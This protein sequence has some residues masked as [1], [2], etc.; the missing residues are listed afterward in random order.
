[1]PAAQNFL[2]VTLLS[3]FAIS[4]VCHA[5]EKLTGNEIA[6]Q[7]VHQ[8]QR[9]KPFDFLKVPRDNVLI[10]GFNLRLFLRPKQFVQTSFVLVRGPSFPYTVSRQAVI[11]PHVLRKVASP[12]LRSICS[13][14]ITVR[15]NKFLRFKLIREAHRKII[16]ISGFFSIFNVQSKQFKIR[17]QG[18]NVFLVIIPFQARYLEERRPE[19]RKL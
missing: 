15:S 14:R 1:M 12:C 8:A 18:K 4:S 5:A 3:I 6:T 9:P 2:L 7:V 16:R 13:A 19:I 10:Y 11:E 17:R